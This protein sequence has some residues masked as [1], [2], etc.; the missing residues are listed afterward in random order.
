[1]ANQEIYVQFGLFYDDFMTFSDLKIPK[2]MSRVN[3]TEAS[4]QG[5]LESRIK[6]TWRQKEITHLRLK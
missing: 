1:M 5:G 4:P 6:V 3:F 2:F